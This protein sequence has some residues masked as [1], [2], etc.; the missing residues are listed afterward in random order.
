MQK[1]RRLKQTLSDVKNQQRLVLDSLKKLTHCIQ[2]RNKFNG[3][4]SNGINNNNNNNNNN[5]QEGQPNNIC[6]EDDSENENDQLP[7]GGKLCQELTQVAQHSY[8]LTI[9]L[10]NT[11]CAALS[12]FNPMSYW[13]MYKSVN[14]GKV[15]KTE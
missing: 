9:A 12:C 5:T 3:S 2:D 10:Y 1:K 8:S 11:T 7:Q 14:T 15:D 4:V 13:D 6:Q